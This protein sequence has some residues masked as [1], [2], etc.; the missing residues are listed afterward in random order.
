MGISAM[1][2]KWHGRSTVCWVSFRSMIYLM[3]VV[4]DASGMLGQQYVESMCGRSVSG[5]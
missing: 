3:S 4:C 2:G 5:V 1:W